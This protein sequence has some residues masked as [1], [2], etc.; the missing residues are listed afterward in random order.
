MQLSNQLKNKRYFFEP[1][2]T[3][4]RVQAAYSLACL[5]FSNS[6]THGYPQE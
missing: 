2:L 4:I 5:V 3:P 6:N 1:S